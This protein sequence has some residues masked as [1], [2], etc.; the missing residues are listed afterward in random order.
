VDVVYGAHLKHDFVDCRRGGAF[1]NVAYVDGCFLVLLPV[2]GV[3]AVL[4][5]AAVF[6]RKH[7]NAGFAPS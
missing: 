6:D 7:T 1:V 5:I 3:L 2:G 4:L